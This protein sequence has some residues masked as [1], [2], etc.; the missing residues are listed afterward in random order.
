MIVSLR[1]PLI[2]IGKMDLT[3]QNVKQQANDL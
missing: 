1:F 3:F 2:V